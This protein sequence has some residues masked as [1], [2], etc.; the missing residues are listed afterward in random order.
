MGGTNSTVG[1]RECFSEEVAYKLGLMRWTE[2]TEK[3]KSLTG[4]PSRGK[5]LCHY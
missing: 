4:V 5:R 1:I 3:E 2:F